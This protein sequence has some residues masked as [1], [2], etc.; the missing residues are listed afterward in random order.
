LLHRSLLLTVLLAAC[1]HST[2]FRPG[3][4]G[5]EGPLAV[6]PPTRLTYNPGQDL[7][8]AWLHDGGIVYTAERT[9]RVDHDRC[10]AFLPP[11]GGAIRQYICKSTTS[12]DSL[13]VFEDAA[14]SRDGRIAYVQVSS[15]RFVPGRA[16]DTQQLVVT[17]S[18]QPAATRV[19]QPLP[20][21]TPWG[22]TY[23]GF[24]HTVWLDSTHIVALAERITRPRPC[25]DCERDTI[26]TGLEIVTIDIS[27]PTPVLALVP[28]TDRASSVSSDPT[29]DTLYFTRNGDSHVYRFVFSA[30]KEDTIFDFGAAGI[31]RDVSVVR[32][33]IVAIVGGH[34]RHTVDPVLGEAQSDS[35]GFVYVVTPA[36]GA[37]PVGD[38]DW[39]FRRPAL[40]PD[41]TR[42]VVAAWDEFART[43]DLWLY[44]IP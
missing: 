31:A 37:A 33:R 9:E 8:P 19:V 39:R 6:G 1:E 7:L 3:S 27:T 20:L 34:V 5:P 16:P 14:A 28:G 17:S 10:L 41:G 2:P 23:D 36:G 25:R 44:D 38:L 29:G 42:F 40:S 21:T 22:Q 32:G 13:N 26:R 43:A 11:E 12:D 30:A 4:Y 24:S 35:G 15:D 18:K